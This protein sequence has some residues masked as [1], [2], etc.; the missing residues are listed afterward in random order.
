MSDI[1]SCPTCGGDHFGSSVCPYTPAPCV[2][3]GDETIMACSDC[4]INSGGRNRVHVCNKTGCRDAH[5]RAH[6]PAPAVMLSDS[7]P[8]V[9]KRLSAFAKDV[10]MQMFVAGPVWDGDLSSKGGRDELA[11]QTPPMILRYEGWQT[12][13]RRGLEVALAAE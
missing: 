10:M 4:A 13:S 9:F 6:P 12:L 5:E 1:R 2:I 7:A 8:V 11:E 3:C